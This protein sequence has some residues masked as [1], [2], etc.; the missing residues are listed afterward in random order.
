MGMIFDG[1]R[2]ADKIAEELRVEV[3]KLS[4]KPKLVT[5]VDQDNPASVAYTKLKAEMAKRLGIEFEINDLKSK[6]KNLSLDNTV[7]GVLLQ[8][9]YP[10]S[11]ELI[12]L[13]DPK[14]DVDGLRGDSPYKPAVVR[15]VLEILKNS[16]RGEV[17][18]VG[19]KGFVGSRL[20]KEIPG[21]MGMDKGDF[22]LLALLK[23]D[24]IISATG[25]VGLIKPEMVKDGVVA[26]DVGYPKGDFDPSTALRASFF[27]PVPG[28]VGPVTVVMLF[29]NL[30][31]AV[32]FE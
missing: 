30:V 8:L 29:K 18:V 7:D 4:R 27:T 9:P 26:I 14:K 22:D 25:R 32:S 11:D 15:A 24:V 19:S 10:N 2:F 3:A 28:G 31:D 17:V 6:I 23:A 5:I 21:A 20:M 1:R 13:I 12:R 16:P